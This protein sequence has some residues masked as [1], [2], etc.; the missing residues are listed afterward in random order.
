MTHDPKAVEKKVKDTLIIN[1]DGGL[2]KGIEELARLVAPML[3]ALES[4]RDFVEPR[5]HELQIKIEQA[6][7]TWNKEMGE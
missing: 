4:V 7:A 3:E 2:N 1:A 5:D 6:I